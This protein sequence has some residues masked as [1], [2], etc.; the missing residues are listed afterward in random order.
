MKLKEIKELQQRPDLPDYI[1]L[2]N[3]QEIKSLA[4]L[5]MLLARN[6]HFS[7]EQV[8]TLVIMLT[9]LNLNEDKLRTLFTVLFNKELY[10]EAMSMKIQSF[11]LLNNLL[12][13]IDTER[14]SKLTKDISNEAHFDK[15]KL[16]EHLSHLT[17]LM[18]NIPVEK[19]IPTLIPL[20]L[21][22]LSLDEKT[23]IIS[24]MFTLAKTDLKSYYK[25]L[26][27]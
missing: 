22:D 5:F 19:R 20:L 16:I 21:E 13:E 6:K 4:P 18:G 2:E 11:S 17:L 25:R 1:D 12:E 7:F 27:K 15:D 8:G 24:Y 26:D 23:A 14:M 3:S 9:L 10:E